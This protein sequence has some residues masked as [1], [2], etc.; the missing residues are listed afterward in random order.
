MFEHIVEFPCQ[1]LFWRR[2]AET[3]VRHRSPLFNEARTGVDPYRTMALDSL[4]GNSLGTFQKY[5]AKMVRDLIDIDAFAV[6]DVNYESKFLLS[7]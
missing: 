3:L 5:A 7:I 6:G 2:S 4:H 1:I